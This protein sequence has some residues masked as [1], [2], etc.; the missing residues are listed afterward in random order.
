MKKI[1]GVFVVAFSA[2]CLN[3]ATVKWQATTGC[4]YDGVSANKVTSG[5]A[6]LMFVTE[7]YTQSSLVDAFLAANGKS[8]ATINA[9]TA[10]KALATGTGTVGTNAR[11][12]YGTSSTGAP[13]NDTTAY[14]VVFNNNKMYISEVTEVTYDGFS[15]ESDAG[16]ESM[17]DSSKKEFNAASGYSEAGWYV[18][19]EP[20]SGLLML[21]GMAGLALKRKHA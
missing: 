8:D 3:A 2:I 1:L 4:L 11:I 18:V 5:T 17:T 14:F 19:P 15:K 10:S 16:F 12:A 20:T 6:Y 21:P 9:M 7:T 13:E